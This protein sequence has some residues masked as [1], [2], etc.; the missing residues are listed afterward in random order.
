[1]K[2]N[3]STVLILLVI[4]V[5]SVSG[6]MILFLSGNITNV[7][8]AIVLGIGGILPLVA[9]GAMEYKRGGGVL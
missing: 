7:G 4:S 3:E 2:M 6:G 1:M 9:L 5:I 8:C